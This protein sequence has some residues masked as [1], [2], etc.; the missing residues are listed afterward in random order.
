MRLIES[1]SHSVDIQRDK[2]C[3]RGLAQHIQRDTQAYKKV[4]AAKSNNIMSIQV[5]LG[6]CLSVQPQIVAKH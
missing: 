2:F 5:T 3:Q 1:V 4:K 6:Q